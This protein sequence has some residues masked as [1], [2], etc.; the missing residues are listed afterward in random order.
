MTAPDSDLPGR[1][2][3][4]PARVWWADRLI[5]RSDQAVEIEDAGRDPQ[6]YFPV[7]DTR[8]DLLGEDGPALCGSGRLA[9]LVTFADDRFRVE[10]VDEGPGGG[11]RDATAKRYPVWG[12]ASHLIDIM[13]VR[14]V[15]GGRYGSVARSSRRR[16][17][18]EGSQMLGQA[19][20]AAAR[21]A[22]GRRVVSG[23]MVFL[24]VADAARPLAFQL[25]EFST[26]RTFSSVGIDV[27]Q[28]G[29]SCARATFL[30]DVTAGDVIR[31]AV[32]APAVAGPYGAQ[33]HDMS[34]MGRDVRVVDGAYRNDS[35]APAGPPEID[36][37]VRFRDVPDDQSI[38]AALMAQFMGHMS[39]A[40]ALRP[41]EGIGQ[42]AA[43]D[44]LSTAIN[45]IGISLHGR[46]RAD[47]WMLYHHD[48]VFAGDGM[49]HSACRV[50][51][52]SGGLVASF[53]V[54]AMVRRFAGGGAGRAERAA[55]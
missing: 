26:G 5:A 52:E 9:G 35:S 18:V 15:G 20:V 42:D 24:R 45:A 51:D 43:H 29:R 16:P 21:H 48:S 50:H 8:M 6:L 53:T 54:D 19:I 23:H 30:L 10:L 33:P 32:A 4:Y 40:A 41:H 39:I 14:P 28:E 31:H 38:H 22:P 36:A 7:A 1:P 25:E 11:G 47:R 46:V 44:T 37:W 2:L 17:V 13:D 34:V 3:P 27:S 55:L 12:D 49:T